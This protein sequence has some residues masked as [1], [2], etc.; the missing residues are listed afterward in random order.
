MQGDQEELESSLES[1]GLD[2]G[3]IKFMHTFLKFQSSMS[4]MSTASSAS[5]TRS[6]MLGNL[7][8]LADKVV[9]CMA[10]PTPQD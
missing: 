9:A 1:S 3:T 6:G 4:S 7:A 2:V 10:Y 5:N 8:G